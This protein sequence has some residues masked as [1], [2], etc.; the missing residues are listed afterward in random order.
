[1][2]A[3]ATIKAINTAAAEKVPGYRAHV[4]I[5]KPG[6]EMLYAGD[7]ILAVCADTEE[8]AE[9]V[10]RAVRVDY[11]QLPF[12][13]KEED[14]LAA[15][16]PNTVGGPTANPGGPFATA[17]F[18]QNAFNGVAATAE[19]NYAVPV[20]A[21]QCLEPHGLVAEWDEGQQNLTVWASTQAVPVTTIALAP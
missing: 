2:H 12:F 17:T 6:A 10:L 1:P 15:N 11:Q 16:N 14:A 20:I 8:H 7:E 3:H 21:H 18:E 5:A 4:I 9:D 19:A 13:V